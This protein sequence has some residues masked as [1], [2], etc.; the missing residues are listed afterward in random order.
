VK[1]ALAQ[2]LLATFVLCLVFVLPSCGQQ[3][4]GGSAGLDFNED[5]EAP[6]APPGWLMAIPELEGKGHWRLDT[7]TFS[8][9]KQALALSPTSK[10]DEAYAVAKPLPA[11]LYAGKYVELSAVVKTQGLS[12]AALVVFTDTKD[13]FKGIIVAEPN[14]EGFKHFKTA[15][16]LPA[17]LETLILAVG[18]SGTTGTAWFDD[19]HVEV[20]PEPPVHPYTGAYKLGAS[21][22]VRYVPGKFDLGAAF[23]KPGAR[24]LFSAADKLRASQGTVEFWVKPLRPVAEIPDFTALFAWQRQP[25]VEGF[26]GSL[27]LFFSQGKQLILLENKDH[28]AVVPTPWQAGEWHHIAFTW[29]PA[30]L[31]LYVDGKP[32]LVPESYHDSVAAPG[33]VFALGSNLWFLGANQPSHCVID[34]FYTYSVQLDAATIAADARRTAPLVARSGLTFHSALD[35]EP[36]LR[37]EVPQATPF[38]R[39]PPGKS[40]TLRLHLPAPGPKAHKATLTWTL[41]PA[42]LNKPVLSHQSSLLLPGHDP[43]GTHTPYDLTLPGTLPPGTYWLDVKLEGG[44]RHRTSGRG[45]VVVDAH[46]GRDYQ[47]PQNPVGLSGCFSK[48]LTEDFFKHLAALGCTWYRMPLDWA[49]LEP[50][51]GEW[52]FERLDEIVS[53]AEKYGIRLV[54]TFQWEK[55]IPDW[56]RKGPT[57]RNT[58]DLGSQKYP[59]DDLQDWYDYVFKVVSRYKG[60]IQWWIPWNEPNLETYMVGASPELY[61]KFLEVTRRAS[62]AADPDS[63]LL[64]VGLASVDL[65]FYEA[66]FK[67]GALQYCDAV[68]THPYICPHDPDE[69][70][71]FFM[72]GAKPGRGTWLEGEKAVHDLIVKYGGQQQIWIGEAGWNTIDDFLAP[73]W[74]V[75]EPL[76][77]RYLAK[78]MVETA[79]TP[80]IAKYLWFSAWQHASFSILRANL[81]PKPAA[82]VFRFLAGKLGEAKLVVDKSDAAQH[83]YVFSGPGGELFAFA[84][85]MPGRQ[86]PLPFAKAR[87]K[88]AFNMYGN[89]LPGLPEVLPP[90]PVLFELKS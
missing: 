39:T 75:P 34:D 78:V 87:V 83:C 29:G 63:K 1:G 76:Q 5:F 62:K 58:G 32:G 12:G 4:P 40:L 56:A 21:P 55:P 81:Q 11:A 86:A 27:L 35:G 7:T 51:R 31:A 25:Y 30:G 8:S 79:G 48:V 49:D 47:S 16:S 43:N 71:N 57:T 68:G 89:R 90:E 74:N 50:R 61:L 9:G 59:P 45:V 54:P 19:V 64:G 69:V 10:N 15:F 44:P 52:H 84:W 20:H 24:L 37:L 26:E 28:S 66:C 3:L 42:G 41:T 73:H 65:P 80:F 14:T 2:T 38:N 72:G 36:M 82:L 22:E 6:S 13:F 53:L 67:L 33:P 18:V 77:A 70:S 60:R 46:S 88:A 23:D 85:S 17:H